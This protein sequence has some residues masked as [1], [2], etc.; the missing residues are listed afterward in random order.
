[1]QIPDLLT[2][3]A[4]SYRLF[5]ILGLKTQKFA[6]KMK[7]KKRIWRKE[8]ARLQSFQF[9]PAGEKVD[10]LSRTPFALSSRRKRR[11]ALSLG[12]HC[13]LMRMTSLAQGFSRTVTR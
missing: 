11:D 9:S 8:R 1:V 5:Y 4:C 13:G 6:A 2:I 12:T 7:M 3:T 10:R